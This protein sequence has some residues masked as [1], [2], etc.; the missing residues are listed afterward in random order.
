MIS[1]LVGARLTYFVFHVDEF[2]E[3]AKIEWIEPEPSLD[4]VDSVTTTEMYTVP[5][6]IRWLDIINPFQSDGTIGIA[7]LVFLGG[8]LFAI[9]TAWLYLK[10]KKIP[11]FKITDVMVPFLALGIGIARIGCFMNGCCYGLPTDLPWGIVFPSHCAAGSTF[12]DTHIHPTQLYAILYCFA[13]AALLLLW[14]KRRKFEG[15]LLAV[16]FVLYGLARALNESIRYYRS[17]MVVAHID[18]MAI[19]VS[20]VISIVMVIIG[21]IMLTSGY[22]RA[23]DAHEEG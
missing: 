15:E 21:I 2:R 19:T 6:S 12:P 8:V 10:R 17:G 14:S 3:P 13:I 23:G 9:P 7:G 4:G 16:F 1:S 22:K 5:G 18:S 11:F 20:M